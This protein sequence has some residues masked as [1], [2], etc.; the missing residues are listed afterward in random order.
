[1]YK[2][3]KSNMKM[4]QPLVWCLVSKNIKHFK[5]TIVL[6]M[7]KT[8][9]ILK[10]LK[11]ILLS[12]ELSQDNFTSLALNGVKQWSATKHD[13]VVT[14]FSGFMFENVRAVVKL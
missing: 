7:F 13:S 14:V 12:N 4:G 6:E 1:M 9:G 5:K 10:R 2:V 8:A 3:I 11:A